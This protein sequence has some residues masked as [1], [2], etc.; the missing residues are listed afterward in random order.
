MIRHSK[1]QRYINDTSR[2]ILSLPPAT[3]I[4]VPI[5]MED[6]MAIAIQQ[7]LV[8]VACDVAEAFPDDNYLLATAI[9]LL[10]KATI[11]FNFIQGG[12]GFPHS[13]TKLNGL[14]RKLSMA[15]NVSLQQD[16]NNL[17]LTLTANELKRYFITKSGG[18]FLSGSGGGNSSE[19]SRGKHQINLKTAQERLAAS[20]SII[21]RRKVS[22]DGGVLPKLRWKWLVATITTGSYHLV[23]MLTNKISIKDMLTFPLI[24][25]RTIKLFRSYALIV[26]THPLKEEEQD[27]VTVCYENGIRFNEL[28]HAEELLTGDGSSRR[29]IRIHQNGIALEMWSDDTVQPTQLVELIE[30][31]CVEYKQARDSLNTLAS[32]PI[33]SSYDNWFIDAVKD[34]GQLLVN[35]IWPGSTQD[36]VIY[37]KQA[38]WVREKLAQVTGW[39]VRFEDGSEQLLNTADFDYTDVPYAR[40]QPDFK[41]LSKRLTEHLVK[42]EASNTR[43]SVFKFLFSPSDE[44][45]TSKDLKFRKDLFRKLVQELSETLLEEIRGI[46]I[47]KTTVAK[48]VVISSLVKLFTGRVCFV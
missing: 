24:A 28:E 45:A 48:E 42:S 8:T 16:V 46:F 6:E 41:L 7:Y 17:G 2:T 21:R 44:L 32:I 13:L 25:Q 37:T 11:S 23:M 9:D 14:L 4:L 39:K 35:R 3:D 47:P 10:R 33:I 15:G 12:N 36:T 20:E 5:T 43:L 40:Y 34:S 38:C 30:T 22:R 29:R 18:R 27:N 26:E 1:G 31:N 19:S